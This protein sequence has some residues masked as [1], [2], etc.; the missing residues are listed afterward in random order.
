VTSTGPPAVLLAVTP[1]PMPPP[2][3]RDLPPA[4]REAVQ[5]PFA[6]ENVPLASST[7]CPYV[8]STW[9]KG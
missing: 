7:T 9:T 1:K 3:S 5:V 4:E 6:S 8:A 2:L